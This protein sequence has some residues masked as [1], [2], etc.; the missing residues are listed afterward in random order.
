MERSFFLNLMMGAG[1]HNQG[2]LGLVE[3]A[4]MYAQQ[5]CNRVFQM[6]FFLAWT[7]CNIQGPLTLMEA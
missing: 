2:I 5:D 4:P 6:S 7:P 1:T 3:S